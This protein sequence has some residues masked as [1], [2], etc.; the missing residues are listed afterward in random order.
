M[1]FIDIETLEWSPTREDPRQRPLATAA[2]LDVL[3]VKRVKCL[4]PPG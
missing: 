3:L 1:R 4:T 2:F